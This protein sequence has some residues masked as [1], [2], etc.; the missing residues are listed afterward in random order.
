MMARRRRSVVPP[1]RRP[2]CGT[3]SRGPESGKHPRL[4]PDF[5]ASEFLPKT[6][7]DSKK[8]R[9]VRE[10]R[11]PSSSS[12][13]DLADLADLKRGSKLFLLIFHFSG[14]R[15][16]IVS[17]KWGWAAPLFALVDG[18]SIVAQ[19]TA[20]ARYGHHHGGDVQGVLGDPYLECS[21]PV[22][23]IGGGP[24]ES[25]RLTGI[26]ATISGHHSQSQPPF[27]V[28]G[29][30]S[31][32]NAAIRSIKQRFPIIFERHNPRSIWSLCPAIV[33]VS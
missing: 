13:A 2:F 33:P 26:Q 28:G 32:K 14:F 29:Q 10:V 8:V 17:G 23:F 9:E 20:Q 5:G 6:F 18:L 21:H 22:A 7:R 27:T 31:L 16:E 1:G 11:G 30:R 15:A 19:L 3:A 25:D 4:E 12:L 24:V